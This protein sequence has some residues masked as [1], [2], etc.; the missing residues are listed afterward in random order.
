MMTPCSP[1]SC[2]DPRAACVLRDSY[3][4][5]A[6]AVASGGAGHAKKMKRPAI[7]WDEELTDKEKLLCNQ[8]LLSQ[9]ALIP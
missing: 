9:S 6:A 5:A 7:A 4:D 1:F 2:S 3:I 8:S